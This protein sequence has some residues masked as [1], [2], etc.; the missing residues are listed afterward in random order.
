VK[1]GKARALLLSFSLSL[2]FLQAICM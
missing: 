1:A 2:V